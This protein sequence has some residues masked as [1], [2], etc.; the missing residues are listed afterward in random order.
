MP[1]G[2]VLLLIIK[3]AVGV[4]ISGSD[5]S[6]LFSLKDLELVLHLSNESTSLYLYNFHSSFF[7]TRT[8]GS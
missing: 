2:A 1:V 4:I 7:K 6:F 8:P 3:Y 5:V